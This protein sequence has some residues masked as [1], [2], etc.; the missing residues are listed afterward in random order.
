[1]Y[2]W[3]ERINEFLEKRLKPYQKSKNTNVETIQDVSN[4]TSLTMEGNLTIKA[5]E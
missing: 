2:I 5:D 1:M 4:S 3:N